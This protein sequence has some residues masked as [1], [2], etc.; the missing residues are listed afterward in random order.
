MHDMR[1]YWRNRGCSALKK[2]K[3]AVALATSRAAHMTS[4]FRDVENNVEAH[5]GQKQRGLWSEITS[6]LSDTLGFMKLVRRDTC[7]EEVHSHL[8]SR[9]ETHVGTIKCR[10]RAV[11]ESV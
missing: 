3:N 1:D 2:L 7:Q 11:K 6:K 5:F 9:V 4:R 10:R 8:S